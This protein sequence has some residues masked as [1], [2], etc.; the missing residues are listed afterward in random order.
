[1]FETVA[2]FHDLDDAALDQFV[3]RQAVDAFAPEQ[4][5]ALGDFA[6]FGPQKVG[7]G[8]QRRRLAGAVGPEEGDDAPLGNLKRYPLQHQDHMVVDDLDV[9]DHER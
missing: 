2:A 8:L 4:Y 1:M 5:L 9:V 7:N 6:A 3:G